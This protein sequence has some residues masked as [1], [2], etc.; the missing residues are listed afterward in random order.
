MLGLIA[1]S[2][3]DRAGVDDEIAI[4]E[5]EIVIAHVEPAASDDSG[6]PKFIRV[7]VYSLGRARRNIDRQDA[8]QRH[9]VNLLAIWKQGISPIGQTIIENR[10]SGLAGI[11]S[12]IENIAVEL[13]LL[14]SS[15]GDIPWINDQVA[16]FVSKIIVTC[17]ESAAS[18][19]TRDL[20]FVS[21]S[22]GIRGDRGL[23][24]I[25]RVEGYGIDDVTV[26]QRG[27]SI[28]IS[29][30][31]GGVIE[32]QNI[33]I[34]LTLLA[35]GE[36]D[37]TGIHR[38]LA[39]KVVDGVAIITR[40]S[41]GRNGVSA[42]IRSHGCTG[43]AGGH[44]GQIK[45]VRG[46]VSKERISERNGNE[47]TRVHR[48]RRATRQEIEGIS[49]SLRAIIGGDVHGGLEGIVK[50]IPCDASGLHRVE[51]GDIKERARATLDTIVEMVRS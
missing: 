35:R 2:E 49:I 13:A 26:R 10:E 25:H 44:S 24:P 33:A 7:S 51:I 36:G 17:E 3:S 4:A 14:G 47:V 20:N 32:G 48:D 29:D 21:I 38:Q 22:R 18:A 30:R 8:L 41:S 5:G 27:I 1:R 28:E 12:K 42:G 6:N 45:R 31:E 37:R 15:D 46:S 9:G 23:N 39:V 11:G 16:G 50:T 40:R 43:R 34:L 19:L